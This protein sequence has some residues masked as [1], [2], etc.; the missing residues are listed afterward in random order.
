VW[1]HRFFAAPFDA[2]QFA[3]RA[4]SGIAQPHSKIASVLQAVGAASYHEAVSSGVLAGGV[5]CNVPS[6]VSYHAAPEHG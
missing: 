4:L 3:V 5:I 2:K 1:G 6:P